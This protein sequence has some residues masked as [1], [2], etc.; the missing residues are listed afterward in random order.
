[1]GDI[2]PENDFRKE[3]DFRSCD[4]VVFRKE[5]ELA[6]SVESRIRKVC[7]HRTSIVVLMSK[8]ASILGSVP[9]DI[10]ALLVAFPKQRAGLGALRAS[11][12]RCPEERSPGGGR[13]GLNPPLPPA[14]SPEQGGKHVKNTLSISNPGLNTWCDECPLLP[15]KGNALENQD[16]WCPAPRGR[17]ELP[18]ALSDPQGLQV[19]I[20][21]QPTH[22]SLALHFVPAHLYFAAFEFRYLG[23]SPGFLLPF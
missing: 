1:M 12:Q 17:K 13:W 19:H 23:R 8:L 14:P 16:R 10:V 22:C 2:C 9:R 20:I 3:H 5:K 18:F 21:H 11:Q 6:K 4:C 7:F 15:H